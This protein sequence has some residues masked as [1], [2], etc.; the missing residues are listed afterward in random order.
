MA[1]TIDPDGHI[2]GDDP[3]HLRTR[4]EIAG[5]SPACPFCGQAV[6]IAAVD[7]G[8]LATAAD[9]RRFKLGQWTCPN[10]LNHP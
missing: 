5:I 10:R 8:S 6:T 9:P 2:Q 7:A 3:E 1:I 4:G